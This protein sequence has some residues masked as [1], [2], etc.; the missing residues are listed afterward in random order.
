[1]KAKIQMLTQKSLSTL[2]V[3]LAVVLLLA[4]SANVARAQALPPGVQDVVKLVQAGISDDVILTQIRNTGAIYNL[5]ADQIIFLKNQGVSQPVIKALMTGGAAVPPAA[6]AAPAAPPAPAPT[7]ALPA[8]PAPAPAVATLAPAAPAVSLDSFQPQLAPYGIWIQVPGYGLC[9]Q[10]TVT[11]SDP[12]WRP[13]FDQGHWLYTDAGWSW[14][15][16]YPWGGIVFHYGRWCRFHGGWVWVPGYDWAP[17][18]V[19]WR[20]ADGYCGWAPLPPVAVYKVG[21]GL[22]FNGQ[23]ALDVDFG[24]GMD[25]FTFVAYDHFWDHNLRPFFLPRDRVIVFFPGSRMLNGYR[26]DN[27][28]FVVEGLGHDHIAAL[29]HHDVRIE[30]DIHGSHPQGPGNFDSRGGRDN[31]RDGHSW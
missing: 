7:P 31:Q 6:S 5:T 9:W 30:P 18:W 17:A 10:P 22:F 15:S 1:M 19:C 21:V 16:D 2:A 4:G 26:V 13:Y 3:G 20:E 14:Q 28:R 8:T 27:G 11:V 24:L 23:P 29:T 25:D 12:A